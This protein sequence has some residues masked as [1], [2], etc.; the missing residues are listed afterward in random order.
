MIA[1][2][3]NTMISSAGNLVSRMHTTIAKNTTRHV[4]LYIISK[5]YTLKCPAL[6]FVTGTLRTMPVA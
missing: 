5:V 2:V 1:P 4:Q 3:E 6:E